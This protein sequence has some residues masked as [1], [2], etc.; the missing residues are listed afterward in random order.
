MESGAFPRQLSRRSFD[1]VVFDL[2]GVLTDTAALHARAWKALF[3]PLLDERGQTPF[4]MGADY[5][6]Y[7]DGKKREDG[8]RSFLDS[9]GIELPPDE[10]KRLAD[11]KNAHFQRLLADKGVPTLDENLAFLRRVRAAGFKTACVSASRNAPGILEAARLEPCFD[12]VVSGVTAAAENLA[13][14]PAPDTFLAAAA[15]LG[16][17]AARCVV[18]EDAESGVA[19]G[20][21]G[22]FGLV[23]GLAG[24]GAGEATHRA[25]TERGADLVVDDLSRVAVADAEPQ[26]S[27]RLPSALERLDDLQAE[28]GT[29]RLAFFLDYDGTLTPI[30]ARPDMAKLSPEMRDTLER[31]AQACLVAIV[32]GRGLADVRGL[33]GAPDLIYAGSHGFEI[34]GPQGLSIQAEHGTEFLPDLD[35]M[36]GFLHRALEPVEGALVE[37]KRFSIAVHYRNVDPHDQSAVDDAVGRALADH[38]GFRKGLGKKVYEIQPNIDWHKGRAVRWLIEALELDL[39]EVLPVYIGDDVTDEDAF[40]AL[41]GDGLGILVRDPAEPHETAARYALES[42]DEVRRFFETLLERMA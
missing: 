9:R 20:R 27:D 31:L 33:V 29:R 2:D 34:A 15:R 7:V 26:T 37:R 28:A 4:D 21:A 35:E 3:D 41:K 6:R 23:I 13:G 25:L 18:I 22:G 32:S 40:R 39:S 38:P 1:A 10:L 24:P 12:T 16:V 17:E 5:R 11:A 30:V 19:A 14:K 8:I 36:E 42:P